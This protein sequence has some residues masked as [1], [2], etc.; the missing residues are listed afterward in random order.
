[1]AELADVLHAQ[2]PPD[3]DE[4]DPDEEGT[5]R[6]KPPAEAEFPGFSD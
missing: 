2:E 1:L 4:N 6:S 3:Y 5:R